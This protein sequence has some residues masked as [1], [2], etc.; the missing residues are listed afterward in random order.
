MILINLL[1][2]YFSKHPKF[3]WNLRSL[4]KRKHTIDFK[5]P[6]DIY[7]YIATS[8]IK[9][10]DNPLWIK[11]ADKFE[12]REYIKN[13]IGEEYL[14]PLLGKWDK[15]EDIDFNSLPDKFVLKTNNSCGTNILVTDKSTLN[16]AE[17][18][19]RLKKWLD[20]PYGALTAQPHYSGINPCIIAERFIEQ[21]TGFSSLVDYKFYCIKD[22]IILISVVSE[23]KVGMHVC[24]II[25]FDENWNKMPDMTRQDVLT[26]R[27]FP[28]P[29]CY[30]ELKGLVK[31]LAKPFEFV[32]IDF[33]VVN[34]KPYFGEFT[35]TPSVVDQLS[36]K[37]QELL[38][39]KL[40]S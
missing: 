34:D 40:K 25:V 29:V 17:I 27:E 36:L 20:Y 24:P 7:E 1:G 32:R 9:N 19:C 35:F 5:S 18:R 6:R 30:E 16:I 11:L 37:G 38:M 21:G 26:D 4:K 10:G 8:A 3:L 22:E 12:V 33:Y 23:R 2:K 39:N 31:Q 28:K 13:T 15:P 14:I